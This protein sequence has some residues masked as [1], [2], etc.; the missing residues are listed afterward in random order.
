MPKVSACYSRPTRDR[1][2]PLA[3]VLKAD[4]HPGPPRN[5]A[6]AEPTVPLAPDVMGRWPCLYMI[7]K[8]PQWNDQVGAYVLNF[9]GRATR[10]SVKNYMLV[11]NSNRNAVTTL[12]GRCGDE[13]FS[14]DV[15]GW[16][17]RREIGFAG[18]TEINRRLGLRGVSLVL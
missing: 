9:N 7:N 1:L 10:A 16:G 17:V 2:D 6:V 12:L 18:R 8:P 11:R 4:G 14:M 15:A 13:L 5:A 3:K